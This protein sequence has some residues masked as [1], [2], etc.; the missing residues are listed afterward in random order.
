MGEY[1]ALGKI[2]PNVFLDLV[3]LPQISKE[4][5]IRTLHEILD[6]IPYNKIFWGGDC[7]IIE[8]SVG[9]LQIAKE[10]IL[11]VLIERLDKGL[12][13]EKIALDIVS[14]I[15]RENAI[16]VFKLKEKLTN[17]L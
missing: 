11:Q 10:V 16:E 17:Q 3:F 14:R 9:S 1:I 4:A 12:I 15:F 13:S 7:R 6:C 5:A 2:F 8:E